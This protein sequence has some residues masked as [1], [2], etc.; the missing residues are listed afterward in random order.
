MKSG[1]YKK[2]NYSGKKNLL[3]LEIENSS[4]VD[5]QL[6]NNGPFTFSK[7]PNQV[8]IKQHAKTTLVLRTPTRLSAIDLPFSVLNALIA[9]GQPAQLTLSAHS[10]DIIE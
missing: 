1:T 7:N 9:P 6:Y 2:R 3:N 10:I 8:T 5:F 4:D